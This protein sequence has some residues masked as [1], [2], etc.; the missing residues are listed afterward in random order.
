MGDYRS[1]GAGTHPNRC[2]RI[3]PSHCRWLGQL[4]LAPLENK[5]SD[6]ARC[7]R[8]DRAVAWRLLRYERLG[9]TPDWPDRRRCRRRGSRSSDLGEKWQGCPGCGLWPPDGSADRGYKEQE[10]LIR[11]QQEQIQAQAAQLKLQQAQIGELSRQ[12]RV[13]QTALASGR[14]T[15]PE[16]RTATANVLAT[17]P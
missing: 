3:R 13:V 15:G 2:R 16:G 17:L 4:E 8:E 5:H 11:R 10:K 9:Q 1:H 14:G 6:A 12:V 7:T